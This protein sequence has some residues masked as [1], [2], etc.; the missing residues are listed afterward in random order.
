M[1]SCFLLH[2]NEKMGKVKGYA[3]ICGYRYDQLFG[4]N[5]GESEL[6]KLSIW[7]F[8]VKNTQWGNGN[9]GIWRVNSY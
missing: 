7:S 4:E 1:P 9:E 3:K 8:C 6:I 5:I 2:E